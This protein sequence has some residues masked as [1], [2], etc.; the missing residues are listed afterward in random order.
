MRIAVAVEYG[1][2]PSFPMPLTEERLLLAESVAL[3]IEVKSD[4]NKQWHQIEETTRKVKVLKRTLKA[5]TIEGDDPP[6]LSIPVIAVGYN[7]YSTIEGLSK[8]LESTPLECRP[9]GALVIDSG[10]F[11]GLGMTTSGALGLYALTLG[12]D[13]LL[14]QLITS[15]PNL[16]RYARYSDF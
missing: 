9:D 11:V 2:S 5:V 4:L 15:R 16:V 8:R 12:I 14:R 7:G 6:P 3:V 1:F 13:V 10:C